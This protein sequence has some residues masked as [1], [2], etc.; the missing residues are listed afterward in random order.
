MKLADFHNLCLAANANYR[1][2]WFN[3]IREYSVEIW[4]DD[5]NYYSSGFNDESLEDVIEK[6]VVKAGLLT[7]P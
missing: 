4:S 1:I 5:Y 7:R 3:A 2:R 6:C